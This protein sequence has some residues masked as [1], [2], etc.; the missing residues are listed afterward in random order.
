MRTHLTS[1][2]KDTDTESSSSSS[3]VEYSELDRNGDYLSV[4]NGESSNNENANQRLS[5]LDKVSG[6]FKIQTP[7]M[8]LPKQLSTFFPFSPQ[9]PKDAPHVDAQ[10]QVDLMES[11]RWIQMLRAEVNMLR[12]QLEYQQDDYLTLQNDIRRANQERKSKQETRRVHQKQKHKQQLEQQHQALKMTQGQLEVAQQNFTALRAEY[13]HKLTAQS[14]DFAL[15]QDQ[16]QR[17]IADLS[18]QLATSASD[19]EMVQQRLTEQTLE[20]KQAQHTAQTQNKSLQ[21]QIVKLEASL[22]E[23]NSTNVQLQDSLRSSNA[24]LVALQQ[25]WQNLQASAKEE[26]AQVVMLTTQNNETK[27][28]LQVAEELLQK[29]IV[30]REQHE[31]ENQNA[32]SSEKKE[33]ESQVESLRLQLANEKVTKEKALSQYKS[34]QT[35]QVL[36]QMEQQRQLNDSQATVDRLK[37]KLEESKTQFK[38]DLESLQAQKNEDIQAST[39]QIQT[40]HSQQ[41]QELQDENAKLIAEL[42]KMKQLYEQSEEQRQEE[43]KALQ[44][45]MTEQLET[46]QAKATER[47]QVLRTQLETV[48]AEQVSKTNSLEAQVAKLQQETQVLNSSLVQANTSRDESIQKAKAWEQKYAD[49]RA[50]HDQWEERVSLMKREFQHTQDAKKELEAQ[51]VAATL[52]KEQVLLR[53]QGL[54][55]NLQALS[56]SNAQL[57]QQQQQHVMQQRQRDK[58]FHWAIDKHR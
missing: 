48:T 15:Q 17:Q 50:D 16:L 25:D 10:L 44:T 56:L 5:V 4:V 19:L 43:T 54:E 18:A 34:A 13:Q 31:E 1:T 7:K 39:T 42:A 11:E 41:Q 40:Q 6:M 24:D 21:Q 28:A 49:L 14:N 45:Q 26:T 9:P 37:T 53:I 47:E 36:S 3:S 32:W 58:D 20:L 29:T 30:E 8:S 35:E 33:L 46:A 2:D 23:A 52:E 22:K 12:E 57:Q 38:T 51:L 27:L 55:A